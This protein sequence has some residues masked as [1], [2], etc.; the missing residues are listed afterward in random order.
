MLKKVN[1]WICLYEGGLMIVGLKETLRFEE[2]KIISIKKLS[3]IWNSGETSIS[4]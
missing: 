1:I 3:G 2:L 4:F